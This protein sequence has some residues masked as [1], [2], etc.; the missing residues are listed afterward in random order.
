MHSPW[1]MLYQFMKETR[2]SLNDLLWKVTLVNL[3]LMMADRPNYKKREEVA[4][5]DSGKNLAARFKQRK[6]K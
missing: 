1:G 3:M 5:P 6:K 4:L 2:W